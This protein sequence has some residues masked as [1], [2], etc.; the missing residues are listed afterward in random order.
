MPDSSNF[1]S[2]GQTISNS[3]L[4]S[5]GTSFSSKQSGNSS[6]PYSFP[7]RV[8][9][10]FD[11]GSIRFEIIKNQFGQGLVGNNIAIPLSQGLTQ[12]PDNTEFV[13]ISSNIDPSTLSL[14]K[15]S[16]NSQFYW[17]STNGAINAYNQG[18]IN[19]S[20]EP[21]NNKILDPSVPSYAIN[22]PMNTISVGS[23]Q[24]ALNGFI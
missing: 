2:Y 1:I 4:G 14:N 13:T 8:L 7:A 11:D 24:S 23:M 3:S 18:Y 20:G 16:P 17:S 21:L 6:L 19:T 15:D 12:F 10:V 9:E 5:V 22:N